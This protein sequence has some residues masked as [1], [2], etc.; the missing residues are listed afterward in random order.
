ML[1]S[2]INTSKWQDYRGKNKGSLLYLDTA[3]YSKLPICDILHNNSHLDPDY[4]K[5]T[6]G[7]SQ[8]VKTQER[9]SFIKLRKS[10]LFFT[11]VYQGTEKEYQG[12][13][14]IF[15]YMH[16][17]HILNIQARHRR[18]WLT[19]SNEDQAIPTCFKRYNCFAFHGQETLFYSIQDSLIL[20]VDLLKQWGY[21][22][23]VARNLKLTLEDE[24]LTNLLTHFKSK[25]PINQQYTEEAQNILEN[26]TELVEN[27]DE[28]D[29]W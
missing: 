18:N 5:G 17:S 12:K 22:G 10:H 21:G 27:I 4:S 28:E 13:H 19:D 7:I 20:T 15:G 16:V 1:D 6:F 29:E 24:R 25:T 26:K 8:C 11:T 3:S 2:N 9:S 14:L 23:R